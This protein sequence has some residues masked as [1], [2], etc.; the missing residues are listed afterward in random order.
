MRVATCQHPVSADIAQNARLI[1]RQ[2]RQA[3]ASGAHVAHFCEGALSGY[4]GVDF[5]TFHGFD[6]PTLRRHTERVMAAAADL[7]LHV[8]LGSSHPLSDGGRPHNSVYIIDAR[9]QLVDRYDKLFCAGDAAETTG[10]LAHYRSGDHFSTFDIHGVRCGVQVCHDYRYP[11]LYR[12]YKRRGVQLMFHSYHAA[13]IGP[14]R[15]AFMRAQVGPAHHRP[16]RGSTLPEITMPASMIA[17]AASSHMWISASNSSARESC[18]P[19]FFVR[20]DGVITGRLRRNMAGV[21]ISEVDLSADLY[22]ST[23]TWRAH[24]MS[25]TFRSGAPVEDPRSANRQEL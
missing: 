10:D 17:A 14:E 15:L 19:A 20:A 18:W 8:L 3:R 24:A 11:E 7:R 2:M 13:H 16:S 1:L 6:W 21:L 25:G 9:G 4:A 23:A 5:P 22:E 12:E